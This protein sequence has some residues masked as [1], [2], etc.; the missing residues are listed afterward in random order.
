MPLINK[1]CVSKLVIMPFDNRL[2]PLIIRTCKNNNAKRNNNK[3]TLK[4][5][6]MAFGFAFDLRVLEPGVSTTRHGWSISTAER[7]T[8]N[9]RAH[10]EPKTTAQDLLTTPECTTLILT[11][12]E[13]TRQLPQSRTRPLGTAQRTT[14]LVTISQPILRP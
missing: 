1:R 5:L 11:T 7:K 6:R 12:G 9:A 10:L 14:R 4:L 2:M 3:G 8:H 13:S